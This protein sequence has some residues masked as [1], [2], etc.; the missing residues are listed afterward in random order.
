MSAEYRNIP[1]KC[2]WAF[3]FIKLVLGCVSINYIYIEEKIFK[4]KVFMLGDGGERKWG[5]LTI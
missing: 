3:R 4:A 1:I 2:P 5:C